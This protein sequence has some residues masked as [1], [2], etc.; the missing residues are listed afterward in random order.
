[1][2]I[3]EKKEIEALTRLVIACIQKEAEHEQARGGS[4]LVPV[5]VSNRHIHL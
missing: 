4:F 2:N 1:M 5:G 3:V